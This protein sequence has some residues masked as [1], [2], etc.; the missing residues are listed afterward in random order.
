MDYPV[1]RREWIYTPGRGW[2]GKAL[3]WFVPFGLPLY[4]VGLN[5]RR[6]LRAELHQIEKTTAQ[7]QAMLSSEKES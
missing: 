6:H 2:V 1:L 3:M 7:I 5:H 4:L